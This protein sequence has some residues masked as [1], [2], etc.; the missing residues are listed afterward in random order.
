MHKLTKSILLVS[1]LTLLFSN[2]EK[3]FSNPVATSSL[4]YP[5]TPSSI[6]SQVGDR[7][8]RL[9]WDHIA[10]LYEV[11]F[12]IFRKDTVAKDYALLD[13]TFSRTY[14][15]TEVLNGMFYLYRI[16][17]IDSNGFESPYSLE[18]TAR[19]GINAILIN[20]GADYTATRN[21]TLALAGSESI[22]FMQIAHDSSFSYA[23][24]ESFVSEREWM[25]QE[26]DGEKGVYARFK[27]VDGNHLYGPVYDAIILDTEATIASVTDNSAGEWMA[28]GDTIRFVLDA[29]EPNGMAS[30]DFGQRI[31]GIPLFDDGTH[32]DVVNNDGI[33]TLDYI[34]PQNI[35]VDGA[36]LIGQF[37]DFLGNQ[38]ASFITDLTI[39]IHNNPSAVRLYQPE[40]VGLNYNALKLYWQANTDVDFLSYK[41]YRSTNAEV[42]STS[43][44]IDVFLEQNTTEMTDENLQ[45]ATT[46]Y[47]RVYV[48]DTQELSSGSNIV[49]ATTGSN[50]PPTAVDLAAP[51]VVDEYNLSLSW[52]QSNDQAFASYRLFRSTG[53]NVT[54]EGI[55]VFIGTAHD[56]T[57]Y[58]DNG[59]TSSTTYY[60]RLYVYDTFGHSSG[61]NIVS[62]TTLP[63][64]PPT[65]VT[66]AKPSA[67]A[68]GALLL[69]WSPNDDSD[70]ES[71][72]LFRSTTDEIDTTAAPVAIFSMQSTTSYTD[73][74]LENDTTYFYQIL[75]YD[76]GGSHAASNI[77]TG[78][79]LP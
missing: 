45:D 9:S 6:I 44:L 11:K 35:D 1:V 21:V 8:V 49:S 20:Q 67:S 68:A 56:E 19:P 71:Y 62:G 75:V 24:W 77:V 74:G 33:Y 29:N 10:P 18:V 28:W 25:L 12:H 66:L 70:F 61:S 48:V 13:S 65:A 36:Y 54:N 39:T 30:I 47:Y 50:L 51:V 72:R 41:V 32:G 3:E 16:S 57:Y 22:A 27:D 23:G 31:T 2:C 37:K 46:Y 55:P 17:A 4:L 79:T 5:E 38:A 42:D 60:Y 26:G 34:V 69:R 43:L 76:K 63:N 59:L 53:S 52:A 15:D 7:Y 64:T 73:L 40:M 14:M 78:T 58:L